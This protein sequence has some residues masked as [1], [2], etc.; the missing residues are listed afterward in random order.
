[1]NNEKELTFEQKVKYYEYQ[2]K[3]NTRNSILFPLIAIIA[4]V[5]ITVIINFFLPDVQAP[6]LIKQIF[7]FT[8][9]VLFLKVAYGIY[10]FVKL[11]TDL[12]LIKMQRDKK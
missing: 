2:I 12:L 1:M 7:V 5:L 11:K 4:I 3:I 8:M 9:A 6:D 10:R